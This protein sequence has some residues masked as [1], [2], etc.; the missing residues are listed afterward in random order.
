MF[1]CVA[2][3]LRRRTEPLRPKEPFISYRRK[4]TDSKV[5]EPDLNVLN[6]LAANLSNLSF[7]NILANIR[8]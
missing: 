5:I 8:K 3:V 1:K 7:K 2:C 4:S 6:N